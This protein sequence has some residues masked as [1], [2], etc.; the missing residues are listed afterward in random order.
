MTF[1]YTPGASVS[2]LSNVTDW[3]GR[4]CTLQYDSNRNLTTF[5]SP[6]G[7]TDKYYYANAGAS[8]SML[9]AIEDPR[10][11]RTT[12]MYDN[13]SWVRQVG[14]SVGGAAWQLTFMFRLCER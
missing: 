4:V 14:L 7:C 1:S 10:G 13:W 11:Y 3:S 5:T 2:L 8:V 6:L 9:N 12:Y